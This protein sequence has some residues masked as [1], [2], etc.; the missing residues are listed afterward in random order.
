MDAIEAL[1]RTLSKL[2]S[3]QWIL[4]VGDDDWRVVGIDEPVEQQG[5]LLGGRSG[6]GQA[7]AQQGRPASSGAYAGISST[8]FRHLL[9]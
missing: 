8:Y 7:E 4:D 9:D 2:G 6:R 3:S 5:Q 1:H